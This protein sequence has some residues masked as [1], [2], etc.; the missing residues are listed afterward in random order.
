MD[1][2]WLALL[3]TGLVAVA[4]FGLIIVLTQ[5]IFATCPVC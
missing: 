5:S 3:I 2:V 4:V 1:K